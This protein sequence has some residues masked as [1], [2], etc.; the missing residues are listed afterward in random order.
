MKMIAAPLGWTFPAAQIRAMNGRIGHT[1]EHKPVLGMPSLAL[2]LCDQVGK[3]GSSTAPCISTRVHP[4]AAREHFEVF[5]CH[6]SHTSAACCCSGTPTPAAPSEGRRAR[7]T[8]VRS[9]YPLLS[10]LQMVV[11]WSV[12]SMRFLLGAGVAVR[13]FSHG[14]TPALPT[15][16]AISSKIGFSFTPGVM[17]RFPFSRL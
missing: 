8:H 5:H 6:T 7:A 10:F 13:K 3:E 4:T 9:S 17:H 12:K 2:A 1:Y 14:F 11:W 15:R 16:P